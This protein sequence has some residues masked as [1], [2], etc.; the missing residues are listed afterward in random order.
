ME[1]APTVKT[2]N[3]TQVSILNPPHATISHIIDTAAINDNGRSAPFLFP[4]LAGLL[5]RNRFQIR[6]QR[7]PL[8]PKPPS[9]SLQQT[10]VCG[11]LKYT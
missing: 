3:P 6:T 9:F 2:L 10:R 11:F 4:P 7:G 5:Q 8:T 1:G